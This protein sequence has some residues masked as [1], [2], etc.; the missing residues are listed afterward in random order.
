[1]GYAVRE[2][3]PAPWLSLEGDSRPPRRKTL[4]PPRSGPHGTET[5]TG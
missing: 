5:R 1:M 4:P 2:R 3:A